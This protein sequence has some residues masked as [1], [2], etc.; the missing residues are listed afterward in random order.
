MTHVGK[1]LQV[2]ASKMQT[3][4]MMPPPVPVE[5]SFRE[6]T[7]SM[8]HWGHMR[9]GTAESKRR[10]SSILKIFGVSRKSSASGNS[11]ENTQNKRVSSR[12]TS[13]G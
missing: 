12:K 2:D 7:D 6:A 1:R 11:D 9:R 4:L 3:E 5:D 10:S 13:R 8:E